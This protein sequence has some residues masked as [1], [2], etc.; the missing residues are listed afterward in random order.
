MAALFAIS[1]LALAGFLEFGPL[2]LR[3]PEYAAKESR[4]DA[5]LSAHSAPIIAF[6]SSRLEE[7]LR[8]GILG[9]NPPIFN[10]GLIGAGPVQQRLALERL[11]QHGACPTRIVFEYW[12]PYLMDFSDQREEYRIDPARLHRHD[13]R[14]LSH[15]VRDPQQ[16][17][18]G[19]L[20]SRLVP[21]HSH[22]FVFLNLVLPVWLSFEKRQD[23]R[24]QPLDDW[25][26]LPG[27][28]PD[29]DP[30]A[31]TNRL[32]LSRQYYEPFLT[33]AGLEPTSLRALDDFLD[34]C[35]AGETEVVVLWMPE[36][37]EFRSW[38]APAVEQK[39]REKFAQLG[40][41][42][43]VR[44]IDARTWIDDERLGDGFHLD[45]RGAIEFTALLDEKMRSPGVR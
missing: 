41:R 30:I 25:G 20:V 33:A 12:P 22:R 2:W 39:A 29:A 43:G 44:L 14:T 23:F 24:W 45:P 9:A 1:Q 15:Y 16:L 19:L 6:G 8:P 10:F 27:K 40:Q 37:S 38:Y 42:P 35:L 34:E 4:L 21:A 18:H 28:V 36:S 17:S 32:R 7:G 31:R 11:K 5:V 26:W 3:D 13:L